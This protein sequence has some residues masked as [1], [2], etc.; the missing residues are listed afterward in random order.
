MTRQRQVL[1]EELRSVR[2][3]PT[4]DGIY[5]MVRRRLPRISLGT[6]YRNLDVLTRMGLIRALHFGGQPM[7]FDGSP[8][9]HYHIR[10]RV[11]GR[12]DDIPDLPLDDVVRMTGEV[13][14]YDVGECR[15]EVVGICPKCGA[16]RDRAGKN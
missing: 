12:L 11:C 15:I 2:T 1:L 13:S 9:R 14:G 3:H 5:Q 4:A 7:R 6:V 8:E 16:H 10:C